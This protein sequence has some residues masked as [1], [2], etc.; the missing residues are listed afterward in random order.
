VN[1]SFDEVKAS[2]GKILEK[3]ASPT[4]KRI[5][6]EAQLGKVEKSTVT[7][8][9][10]NKFPLE[11]MME[12]ANRVSMEQAFS[13]VLNAHVKLMAE[14]QKITRSFAAPVPTKAADPLPPLPSEPPSSALADKLADF[15]EGE[16]I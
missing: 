12:Q 9:Y 5:F 16:V 10:A 4:A 15:F 1:L 13:E 6:R 7:L 14:V 8:Y 2:W 11:K 3:I